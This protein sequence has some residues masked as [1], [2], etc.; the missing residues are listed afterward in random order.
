M[1]PLARDWLL[2]WK[3]GSVTNLISVGCL[4]TGYC[5]E[6]TWFQLDTASLASL[7]RVWFVE[8]G[9]CRSFFVKPT[10]K[11]RLEAARRPPAPQSA[12]GG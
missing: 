9:P 5:Y 8:Y 2:W 6:G 11:R 4:P 12:K 10:S 3:D 1:N 7:G